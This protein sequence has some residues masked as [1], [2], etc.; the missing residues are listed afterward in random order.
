MRGK[1]P[2]WTFDEVIDPTYDDPLDLVAKELAA[3]R[4]QIPFDAKLSD[5]QIDELI[6]RTSG[7]AVNVRDVHELGFGNNARA[8]PHLV[9]LSASKDGGVMRAAMSSLGVLR[10]SQQLDLLAK[11]A[12]G[13]GCCFEGDRRSGHPAIARLS[14]EQRAGADVDPLAGGRRTAA[15]RLPRRLGAQ[16]RSSRVSA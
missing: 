2:A 5:T 3:K 15:S 7:S 9:N 1:L 12:G 10:A 8:I 14:R 6:A 11:E 16:R 4:D 13:S